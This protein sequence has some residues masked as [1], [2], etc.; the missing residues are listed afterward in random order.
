VTPLRYIP[1]SLGELL[2]KISILRIK[3]QHLP[4]AEGRA[5]VSKE[6]DHLMQVLGDPAPYEWEL[7][8]FREHNSLIWATEDIIRGYL[9]AGK[10]TPG[11]FAEACAMCHNANYKRFAVKDR[12]NAKYDSELREQ[13]NYDCKIFG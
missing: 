10:F 2:D 5:Y 6:L 11:L 9:T 7:G 13:K 3:L 8:E 12:V 4:T 1:I